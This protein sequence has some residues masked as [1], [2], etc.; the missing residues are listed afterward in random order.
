M[1]EGTAD[2]PVMRAVPLADI[3]DAVV[4]SPVPVALPEALIPLVKLT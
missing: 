1:L 3:P 2:D 4:N